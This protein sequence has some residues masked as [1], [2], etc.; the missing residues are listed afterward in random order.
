MYGIHVPIRYDV[1]ESHPPTNTI[2][3]NQFLKDKAQAK[4]DRKSKSK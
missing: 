2:E 1:E 3:Y 4:R